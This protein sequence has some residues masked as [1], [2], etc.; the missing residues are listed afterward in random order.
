MAMLMAVPC[1]P[2]VDLLCAWGHCWQGFHR[3]RC[4][5]R[6]CTFCQELTEGNELAETAIGWREGLP[7]V[8][9]LFFFPALSRAILIHFVTIDSLFLTRVK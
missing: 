4:A 3:G 7:G 1:P 6:Q 5:V 2:P 9:I 8:A